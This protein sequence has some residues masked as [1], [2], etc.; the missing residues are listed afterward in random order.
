[1]NNNNK[2]TV[3]LKNIIAFLKDCNGASLKNIADYLQVSEMT[4][5][6]D[7]YE[8]REQNVIH[9]I[10]G[11][12]IFNPDS[13]R[14]NEQCPYDLVGEKLVN[15]D[16]KERIGKAAATLLTA[17]DTVIIDTGTTTEHFAKHIPDQVPLTVL[18]YNINIMSELIRRSHLNLLFAGGIYHENTQMFESPEGLSL[19]NR[20]R[21]TKVFLSAAGVSELLGITCRNHYE[22]DTK[23]AIINAALK[24]ILLVD[25]SKFN[26]IRPALFAQLTDIDTIVTDDGISSEWI[27]ILKKND[28]EILIA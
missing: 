6:R 26:R 7:L 5:R 28:I 20:T 16:M 4:A 18:C 2:K 21:A 3:R 8:L 1:M 13:Q 23:R 10:S 27:E 14:H 11:V 19:I 17:G 9:Y 24:R 25:S 15:N 12:A 22:I